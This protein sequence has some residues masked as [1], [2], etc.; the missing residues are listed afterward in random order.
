MTYY[1]MLFSIHN[2]IRQSSTDSVIYINLY[3][4][5]RYA[6]FTYTLEYGSHEHPDVSSL[7]T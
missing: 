3:K 4:R 1:T 7:D 6:S 2:A 5:A